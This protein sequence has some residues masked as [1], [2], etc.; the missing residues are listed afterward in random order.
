MERARPLRFNSHSCHA[1]SLN[2]LRLNLPAHCQARQHP[3]NFQRAEIF[4]EHQIEPPVGQ[5]CFRRQPYSSS[6]AG[7]IKNSQHQGGPLHGRTLSALQ[8]NAHPDPSK[9]TQRTN[10]RK[11]VTASPSHPAINPVRE[12]CRF[13][14]Q[15]DPSSA[16]VQTFR[17]VCSSHL[18]RIQRR[19][20]ALGQNRFRGF[21][22][23]QWQSQRCGQIVSTTGRQNPNGNVWVPSHCI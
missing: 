1:M 2:S 10:R 12:L 8:G 14:V 5:A 9:S 15:P 3:D 19:G 20:F 21:H 16:H 7:S 6:I 11:Q 4:K 17:T 23:I 13:C 22:R 18:R